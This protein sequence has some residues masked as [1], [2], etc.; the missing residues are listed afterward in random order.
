[1][2]LACPACYQLQVCHQRYSHCLGLGILDSDL[3]VRL[4][5]STLLL[6]LDLGFLGLR[7]LSLYLETEEEYCLMEMGSF[8]KRETKV[9]VRLGMQAAIKPKKSSIQDQSWGGVGIYYQNITLI[10]NTGA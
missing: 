3:G 9:G 10:W 2:L 5:R 7:L 1:M 4:P 8:A 6:Q